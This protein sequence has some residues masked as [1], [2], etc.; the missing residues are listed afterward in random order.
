MK[1]RSQSEP[2]EFRLTPSFHTDSKST[3]KENFLHVAPVIGALEARYIDIV[4]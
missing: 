1:R 4:R 2:D 3:L